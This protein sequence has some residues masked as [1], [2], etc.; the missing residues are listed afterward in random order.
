MLAK[1]I[2]KGIRHNFYLRILLVMVGF[3]PTKSPS[4]VCD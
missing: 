4:L 1:L 2:Y 3:S